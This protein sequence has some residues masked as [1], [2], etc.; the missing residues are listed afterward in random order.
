[1]SNDI[2]S[3]LEKEIEARARAMA[4]QM[5]KEMQRPSTPS[6]IAPNGEVIT[7]FL[8]GG[9]KYLSCSQTEALTGVKYPC[10]WK[11]NKEGKLNYRKVGGRLFFLYD[12]VQSL[13][14]G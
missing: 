5:V 2:V 7:P 4:E 10:L 14:N 12:D 1:M 8:V 3:M 6:D 11:W 13:I 9:K